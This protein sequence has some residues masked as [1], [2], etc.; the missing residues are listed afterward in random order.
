MGRRGEGSGQIN[1]I[2]PIKHLE[3]W[4][5]KKWVTYLWNIRAALT[6]YY[7]RLFKLFSIVIIL[8]LSDEE[9]KYLNKLD[10]VTIVTSHCHSRSF[11]WFHRELWKDY[12]NII[13]II[14]IYSR[15]DI[16]IIIYM[17]IINKYKHYKYVCEKDVLLTCIDFV[18]CIYLEHVSMLQ[19]L[20]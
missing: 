7:D 17:F 11:W 10:I 18:I 4:D 6:A 1:G 3:D 8:F 2:F 19:N 12:F 15:A 16:H 14:I 20:K 5:V 13:K 9:Q